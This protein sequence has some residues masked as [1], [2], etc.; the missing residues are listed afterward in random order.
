M[1]QFRQ[2]YGDDVFI[3]Q[4]VI[5]P[6]TEA[7]RKQDYY[8]NGDVVD[9][10]Y[11]RLVGEAFLQYDGKSIA[12]LEDLGGILAVSPLRIGGHIY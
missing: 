7:I 5:D 11:G 12:Q 8:T 4:E 10:E 2:D 3:Y 9:F 1:P 6:G